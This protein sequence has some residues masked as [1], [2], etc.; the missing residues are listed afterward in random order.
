[1]SVTHAPEKQVMGKDASIRRMGCPIRAVDRVVSLFI[2]S[3]RFGKFARRWLDDLP[4]LIACLGVSTQRDHALD[5]QSNVR[6]ASK[7]PA[8]LLFWM[9][10]HAARPLVRLKPFFL[11]VQFE[12]RARYG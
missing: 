2:T 11:H 5:R 3:S 9:Q 8:I 1:M 6:A 10:V 7:F 12:S 4:C